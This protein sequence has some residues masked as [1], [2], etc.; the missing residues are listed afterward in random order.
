MF[1]IYLHIYVYKSNYVYAYTAEGIQIISK[2][3]EYTF[4][5]LQTPT[6]VHCIEEKKER[7]RAVRENTN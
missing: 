7:E 4:C 3:Y 1:H 5:L 2:I 6:T